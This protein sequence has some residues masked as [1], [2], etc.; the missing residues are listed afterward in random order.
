MIQGS[1][2]KKRKEKESCEKK[3]KE[4]RKEKVLC[5]VFARVADSLVPFL[6]WRER[7]RKKNESEQICLHLLIYN[8]TFTSF[9]VFL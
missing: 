9:F 6:K 4:K 1:L 8:K 5:F 3:K 2:F 7:N